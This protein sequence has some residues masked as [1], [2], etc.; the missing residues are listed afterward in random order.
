MFICL[1]KLVSPLRFHPQNTTCSSSQF[2]LS[3]LTYFVTAQFSGKVIEQKFLISSKNISE[4][5]HTT[6]R[7][8]RNIIIKR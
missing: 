6:R 4:K 3:N 1:C 5:F 7:I 8:Q 2:F